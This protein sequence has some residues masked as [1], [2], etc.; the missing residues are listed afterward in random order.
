MSPRHRKPTMSDITLTLNSNLQN[1]AI[2]KLHDDGR[3]WAD[4]E[5]QA[6]KVMG[7]KGVRRPVEGTAIMPKP[8]NKVNGDYIMSDRKTLAM[9]E[10]I[11]AHD[12]KIDEYKKKEF[13][14]QHIIMSMTLPHL[15]VKI[16]N[17]KMAKEMWDAVKQDATTKS[18]VQF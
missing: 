6:K 17:L 8:F 7:A 1:F 13:L 15:G 3:N 5:L 4:Y 9:E 11:E 2:P 16:K 18:T 14:T 10:Q 12:A